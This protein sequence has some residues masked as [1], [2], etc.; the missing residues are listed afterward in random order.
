MAL[1]LFGSSTYL[2][3][4]GFVGLN[5]SRLQDTTKYRLE[6]K[7]AKSD[8][9]KCWP[10]SEIAKDD[11]NRGNF[12]EAR[13]YAN[14]LLAIADRIQPKESGSYG[15]AV[16]DGNM[17]L[18]RLAFHDG[19]R[20]EAKKFLL[21]SGL[22]LGAPTLDSFGPNMSL[23][24]SLIEAGERETVLQYFKECEKFWDFNRG[25]L[26]QWQQEVKDGH[27]PYFGANMD[28]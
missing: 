9:E 11:F 21:K 15:V 4:H 24:K 8:D 18:G 3:S 7:D 25:Q 13:E 26:K 14:Q 17:V 10:L 22:T 12:S 5:V 2:L 20:E 1:V 28:Y 6:L 19:K 23:A 16:H 27:T